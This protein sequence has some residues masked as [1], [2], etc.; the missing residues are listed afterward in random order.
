MKLEKEAPTIFGE[1]YCQSWVA[2]VKGGGS[3]TNIFIETL[4]DDI[5]LDSVYFRGKTSKL[6]TKPTNKQLFIGRFLSTSNTEKF[7]FKEN[8]DDKAIDGN[9]PFE[10]ENNECV[11]SYIKDGKTRYYKL[12]NII[13]RQ[14]DALPMSTPP[15]K[16]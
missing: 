3:G 15:I 1:V 16:N 2:G 11:V 5:V 8:T 14:T 10:L 6:T 4:K 12:S 9:S 7:N 13:E